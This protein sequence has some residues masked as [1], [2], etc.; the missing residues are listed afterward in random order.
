MVASW[1]MDDY[2]YIVLGW[3]YPVVYA[4]ILMVDEPW[5]WAI[6]GQKHPANKEITT[7]ILGPLIKPMGALIRSEQGM[8]SWGILPHH[9]E[10]QHDLGLS[11]NAA[12]PQKFVSHW[13]WPELS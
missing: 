2:L 5:I 1:L 12:P 9:G 7:V 4:W 8:S 3:R 10:P 13:I 11:E 6:V